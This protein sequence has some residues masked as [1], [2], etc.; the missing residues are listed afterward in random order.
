MTLD[1]MPSYTHTS[2]QHSVYATQA[3]S[4]APREAGHVLS[5]ILDND[6]ALDIREHTLD[7][8]GLTE[9]LFGLCPLL[10]IAFMPRLKDLP[11]QV[12]SRIDRATDY[13]ALQ[14]LLRGRIN[15]ALILE[16]WDQ[17]VRLAAS[18]KDR[19]TRPTSSCSAWPTRT[20]RTASQAP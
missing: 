6:T 20:P 19:L 3:I 2:D 4:C 13:G 18:L 7:T 14:P 15:V 5:G 17:L 8:H 1:T 10:G 9:H 12:L 16:Q 11:D